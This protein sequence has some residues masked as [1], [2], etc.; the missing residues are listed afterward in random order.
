[1]DLCRHITAY[2][3]SDECMHSQANSTQINLLFVPLAQP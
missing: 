3:I 2:N 1:L